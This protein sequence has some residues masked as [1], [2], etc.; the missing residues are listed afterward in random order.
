MTAQLPDIPARGFIASIA[1]LA[2]TMT[3]SQSDE[4]EP[5]LPDEPSMWDRAMLAGLGIPRPAIDVL[6]DGLC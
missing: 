4:P 1:H 5:Y 6:T 2:P 3:G